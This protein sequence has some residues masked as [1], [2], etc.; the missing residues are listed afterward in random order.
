MTSIRARIE[1]QLHNAGFAAPFV[2]RDLV[3]P[4]D[5]FVG[6]SPFEGFEGDTGKCVACGQAISWRVVAEDASGSVC[7]LGR[8][9]AKAATDLD[10]QRIAELAK[11]AE[12]NRTEALRFG[13]AP[14][15]VAFRAWAKAQPHPKSWRGKTLLDDLAYWYGVA[16]KRTARFNAAYKAYT[17]GDSSALTAAEQKRDAKLVERRVAA[18]VSDVASLA[19]SLDWSNIRGDFGGF[20]S[21]LLFATRDALE[22]ATPEERELG[23][24]KYFAAAQREEARRVKAIVNCARLSL[25]QLRHKR[26]PS[27][28][29]DVVH[30]AARTWLAANED[31]AS[32]T[33]IRAAIEV[34]VAV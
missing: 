1:T 16:S 14:E 25:E 17:K 19:W 22:N 10:F 13:Q 28:D 4:W 21:D 27:I 5:S 6:V 31:H 12:K 15:C 11:R 24:A 18:L 20:D 32:A 26:R 33:T 2:L 30:A 7:V 8:D 29:L 23:M 34:A 9:C 3:S